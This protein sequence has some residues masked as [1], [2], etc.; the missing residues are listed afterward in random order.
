MPLKEVALEVDELL[1]Q[2]KFIKNPWLGV[3][4]SLAQWRIHLS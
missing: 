1:K 4:D 3:F 2:E